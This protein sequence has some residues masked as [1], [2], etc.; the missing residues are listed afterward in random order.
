MNLNLQKIRP[1]LEKAS[2]ELVDSGLLNRNATPRIE[3]A[4][5]SDVLCLSSKKVNSVRPR[6]GFFEKI[7]PILENAAL[8]IKKV[9]SEEEVNNK[10][11]GLASEYWKLLQKGQPNGVNTLQK[12]IDKLIP[13]NNMKTLQKAIDKQIPEN[14]IEV[15]QFKDYAKDYG[16]DAAKKMNY[17]Q[18]MATLADISTRKVNMYIDENHL[19]TSFDRILHEFNH[20]LFMQ[21]RP[22]FASSIKNLFESTKA[23]K[24]GY[25]LYEEAYKSII[26]I[27]ESKPLNYLIKLFRP[28]KNQG[29]KNLEH[30]IEKK[31]GKR[32]EKIIAGKNA[33]RILNFLKEKA[34]LEKNAYLVQNSCLIGAYQQSSPELLKNKEYIYRNLT[35]DAYFGKLEEFW[36]KQIQKAENQMI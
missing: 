1:M 3:S 29:F 33:T 6:G 11:M 5:I 26:D 27:S 23:T 32:A 22:G 8:S 24:I 4:H 14:N 16:E 18:S 15:K 21:N 17:A 13:E 28:G 35:K 7:R 19:T 12:A 34:A 25:F 31:Y 30:F 36:A 9:W 2:S 10:S 20:A